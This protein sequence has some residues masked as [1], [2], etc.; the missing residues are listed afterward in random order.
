MKKFSAVFLVI[1]MFILLPLGAVADQS[2]S[3]EE[4]VSI[5]ED[6]VADTLTALEDE[7]AALVDEVYNYDS[8][9]EN[10]DTIKTFYEKIGVE[11][12]ILCTQ[13]Q[14]YAADYAQAIIDRSSSSYDTYDELE[15]VYDLIYDDMGD[16]IYSRIYDGILEELYDSFYD[17]AL[18]DSDAAPYSDWSKT[19]SNE[20][21]AWSSARSD[22]YK[23]WSRF[24]SDV[25]KFW[26]RI[27]TDIYKGKEERALKKVT[28]FREN[29]QTQLKKLTSDSGIDAPVSTQ[30][31]PPAEVQPQEPTKEEANST[32]LSPEFKKTMD[33]YEAF[34]DE[35]VAF[36]QDYSKNPSSLTLLAK[37]PS[38]LQKY[39]E[40]ITALENID[41]SELTDAEALYYAEVTLR[42]TQKLLT[43]AQ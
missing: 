5:I 2:D 29:A 24:R 8:Y 1:I 37:Y 10:Y 16:E 43:V 25:Y 12:A 9:I 17:G 26:S 39:T 18:D 40:A 22:T 36:M 7:A 6:T 3:C 13:M 28:N 27:R 11:S 30:S 19:R 21:K 41:E 33:S 15:N 34:F 4:L 42:I 20:Y 32:V 14:L 38:F 31:L 23:Q 35:Y